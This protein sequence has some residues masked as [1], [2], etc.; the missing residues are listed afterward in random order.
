MLLYLIQKKKHNKMVCKTVLKAAEKLNTKFNYILKLDSYVYIRIQLA[1][2]LP[3]K[4]AM[5]WH[6]NY[7]DI[8]LITVL[9]TT[10]SA[11][12]MVK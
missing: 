10:A 3:M 1:Q 5:Q 4:W 8:S 2:D 6:M 9:Q 12:S 11:E 7:Q